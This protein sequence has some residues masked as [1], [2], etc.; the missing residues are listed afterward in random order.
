MCVIRNKTIGFAMLFLFIFGSI[1]Y[2]Q[3]D[4][5]SIKTH[6]NYTLSNM[7]TSGQ[8]FRSTFNAGVEVRRRIGQNGFHLQSGIRWNEFGYGALLTSFLWNGVTYV[9]HVNYYKITRFYISLPVIA[10]WKWQ[11]KV[12]GF[13]IS[14][15]T[16]LS[17]LVLRKTTVDKEVNFYTGDYLPQCIAHF[18]IGYERALNDRWFLGIEACT[19]A[20]LPDR[21]YNFGVGLSANYLLK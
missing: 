15:G 11:E 3:T 18:S 13:T 1:S 7:M 19:N 14:A 21:F 12:P 5:Y 4:R 10:T 17:F 8:D 16:Q 9:E 6:I 2:A 20:I